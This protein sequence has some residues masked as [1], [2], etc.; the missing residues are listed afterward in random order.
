MLNLILIHRSNV[1]VEERIHQTIFCNKLYQ[2]SEKFIWCFHLDD[3]SNIVDLMGLGQREV[4]H[5]YN[6]TVMLSRSILAFIK[7]LI[8][9]SLPTS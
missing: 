8:V 7:L 2:S 6:N 1:L 3:N 4:L 5:Y 9:I